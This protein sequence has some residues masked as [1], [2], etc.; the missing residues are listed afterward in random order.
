MLH[1][2]SAIT[3]DH[4]DKYDTFADDFLINEE[5]QRTVMQD[6]GI[7]DVPTPEAHIPP[8]FCQR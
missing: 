8:R 7:W 2:I 5:R 3:E 4:L 1:I 6:L